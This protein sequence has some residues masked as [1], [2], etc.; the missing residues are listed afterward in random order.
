MNTTPPKLTP[1]LLALIFGLLLSPAFLH[2]E[3]ELF[4][5]G[6]CEVVTSGDGLPDGFIF[7]NKLDRP[8][9][10]GNRAETVEDAEGTVVRFYNNETF[11]FFHKIKAG[12][13]LP[14]GATE[15]TISG[16]FKAEATE[17]QASSDWKGYHMRAVFSEAEAPGGE[18]ESPIADELIA[19]IQPM[20]MEWTEQSKTLPI[21][22]GAKWV[23][24]QIMV[25]GLVGT[26]WFDDISIRVP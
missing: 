19:S 22:P 15:I 24:V 21:P 11:P 26:F 6:S 18:P 5:E 9:L 16:R 10:G 14:E 12:V 13:P 1:S 17:A 25:N 8:W 7:P 2:A 20:T 3:T 23:T 4:P